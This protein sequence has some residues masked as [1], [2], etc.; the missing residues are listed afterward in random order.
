MWLCTRTQNNFSRRVVGGGLDTSTCPYVLATA[1]HATL[2]ALGM[3]QYLHLNQPCKT[4][5]KMASP[6][7]IPRERERGR[8]RGRQN[9]LPNR[10]MVQR[11]KSLVEMEEGES[12]QNQPEERTFPG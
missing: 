10:L 7:S 2:T 9:Q 1:H 6:E 3:S 4:E 12:P 5:V 11:G 8:G